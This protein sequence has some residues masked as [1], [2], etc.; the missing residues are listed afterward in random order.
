M[1]GALRH[2][3]QLEVSNTAARA[4]AE[5]VANEGKSAKEA[6]LIGA[7]AATDTAKTFA[8]LFKGNGNTA[9][10]QNTAAGATNGPSEWQSAGK[11]NKKRLANTS[12]YAQGT[13]EIATNSEIS[14]TPV[15]PEHA[16]NKCI[17]ISRLNLD[18][19]P[20]QFKNMI[21]ARAK[22]EIDCRY[23]HNLSRDYSSWRTIAIELNSEDCNTLIN[24]NFWERQIRI[25]EFIGPRNSV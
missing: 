12:P 20:A 6:E 1:N 5:A 3:V 15:R 24:P 17:V 14:M 18:M 4:A 21:N 16:D 10:N 13:G 8:Q 11:K 22:R 25:R 9:A 19:S 2:M 7:K 23:I